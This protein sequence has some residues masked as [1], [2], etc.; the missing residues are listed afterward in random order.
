ME[1]LRLARV[2]GAALAALTAVLAAVQAA[3][4]AAKAVEADVGTVRAAAALG[5]AMGTMR[6]AEAAEVD[7]RMLRAVAAGA[8]GTAV[9]GEDHEVPR[10][11]MHHTL[12]DIERPLSECKL[13]VDPSL[14][15]ARAK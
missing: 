11:R 8:V 10:G 13:R 7:I 2:K 9:G 5:A 3:A 4:E 14:S 15:A 1:A 6:A 12:E